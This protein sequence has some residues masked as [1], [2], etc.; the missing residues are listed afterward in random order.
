MRVIDIEGAWNFSHE[1]L[2]QNQSGLGGQ[3]K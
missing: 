1:D 3:M 2:I